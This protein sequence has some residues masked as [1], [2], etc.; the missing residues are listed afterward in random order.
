MSTE[1]DKPIERW[2]D[3][4][5]LSEEQIV[6]RMD[7][8]TFAF[9][10]DEKGPLGEVWMLLFFAKRAEKTTR[11]MVCLTW[12]IALMTLV[13]TIFVV[14]SATGAIHS[15]QTVTRTVTTTSP[16]AHPHP[17]PRTR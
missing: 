13:S 2:S 4:L 10:F 15:T 12:A 5:S 14:L 11:S 3:L 17:G 7:E 6:D 1:D 9:H 16:S 8:A